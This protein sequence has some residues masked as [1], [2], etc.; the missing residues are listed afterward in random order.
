[1][2][3]LGREREELEN[4]VGKAAARKRLEFHMRS[5]AE[6]ERETDGIWSI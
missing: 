4:V 6:D 2:F 3:R 5:V 1:M